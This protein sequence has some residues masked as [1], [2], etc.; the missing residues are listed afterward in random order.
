MTCWAASAHQVSPCF[1][2]TIVTWFLNGGAGLPSRSF[3]QDLPVDGLM[4]SPSDEK[5]PNSCNS[6]CLTNCIR[7][8]PL[9]LLGT[10]LEY[11]RRKFAQ[12]IIVFRL[13]GEYKCWHQPRIHLLQNNRGTTQIILRRLI[14]QQASRTTLCGDQRRFI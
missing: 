13:N 3:T 10:Y 14:F 11:P 5:P 8:H 4:G 7:Q 1:A 6:P 2:S 12:R 9:S